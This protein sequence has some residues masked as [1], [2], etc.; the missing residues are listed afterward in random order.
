M[1]QFNIYFFKEKSRQIDLDELINYFESIEGI[2][3]DMDEQSVR[4]N[5]LHPRLHYPAQFLIT[6]KSTVPDIYRLNPKF[7]DLNFHLSM[8]IL[9]PD[10]VTRHLFEMVKRI[11][12]RFNFHVYNEMLEDVLPFKMDVLLKVFSMVKEAY[13][14]KNPVL[15]GDYHVLNT[16]KLSA[17]LRYLDDL[18]ELQSY[19]KDLETYVPRYHFLSNE[20]KELAIGIEWKE[21]TL[22]VFPPHL[23]YLFYRQGD[24]LKVVP[25]KE[26]MPLLDKHLQDVPGF[27]KGTKVVP[28]KT[29]KKVFRIMKKTKFSQVGHTFQKASVRH[30]ID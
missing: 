27:I 8:P 21:Q 6:P 20:N 19:Y 29:A 13:I 10:F 18:V 24:T 16:D 25:C 11:T 7:L 9:T 17:I 15:L 5:Y 28:K 14:D 26:A 12:E 23:N 4:F 3:I 2:T 30:L 22:T 1:A